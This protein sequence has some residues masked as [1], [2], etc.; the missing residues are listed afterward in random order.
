MLQIQGGTDGGLYVFVWLSAKCVESLASIAFETAV[1]N[2]AIASVGVVDDM[3]AG[4]VVC[5][6][7]VAML[8]IRSWLDSASAVSSSAASVAR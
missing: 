4:M 3:S 1:T 6:E 7:V 8:A 5:A 2:M